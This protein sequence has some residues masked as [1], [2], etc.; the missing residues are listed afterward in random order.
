MVLGGRG[1]TVG[2]LEPR[3]VSKMLPQKKWRSGREV[4]VE[5]QVL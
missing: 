1:H 2:H 5:F 4:E 3:R